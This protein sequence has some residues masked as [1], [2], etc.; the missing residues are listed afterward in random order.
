MTQW[1]A[2]KRSYVAAKIIPG[3]GS[4]VYMACTD[5]VDM[6]WE[7][8]GF[9]N[10]IG[11]NNVPNLAMFNQ[12]KPDPVPTG[13]PNQ[14]A[15]NVSPTVQAFIS[16]VNPVPVSRSSF[17]IPTPN[18]TVT[19]G[20]PPQTART[21][22]PSGGAPNQA[23]RASGSIPPFTNRTPN[24]SVPNPAPAANPG[25]VPTSSNPVTIQPSQPST[26][27]NPA[28]NPGATS[29]PANPPA[30]PQP[31]V[32]LPSNQPGASPSQVP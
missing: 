15:A 6:G 4:L 2:D 5:D 30:T 8:N 28:P 16:N 17:P 24:P 3:F 7:E 18:P 20:P 1:S 32:S 13:F 14:P 11:V 22:L 19:F 27:L 12:P 31:Q 21:S 9:S 25:A 10:F 26:A 29:V 23:S